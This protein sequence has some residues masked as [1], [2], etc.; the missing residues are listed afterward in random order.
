MA[1]K[2]TKWI[3]KG[4]GKEYSSLVKA[5]EAEK[6]YSQEKDKERLSRIFRKYFKRRHEKTHRFQ[7]Y[8]V[9]CGCILYEFEAEWDGH[10]NEL[11]QFHSHTHTLR[12][13]DGERCE[14]C[15]QEA[16]KLLDT[17]IDHYS[18]LKCD[19]WIDDFL[20]LLK[21]NF[22]ELDKNDIKNILIL[23]NIVDKWDKKKYNKK[24]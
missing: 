14:K 6:R 20:C 13:F 7:T 5:E 23:Y 1:K 17:M 12:L 11:G 24:S 21:A 3:S 9:D 16:D 10:R 8:C 4:E 15:H 18:S 2:I 19:G 22:D